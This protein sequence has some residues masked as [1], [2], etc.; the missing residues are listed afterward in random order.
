MSGVSRS[1]A[2]SNAVMMVAVVV[3]EL[4]REDKSVILASNALL[5]SV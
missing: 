4:A 3:V 5:L 1:V 2:A